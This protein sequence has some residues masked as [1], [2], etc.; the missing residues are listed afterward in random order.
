MPIVPGTTA[1]V[2][3]VAAARK[4]IAAEI[5][6]PVAVKAAGGG[7]GKG[8]RV[9]ATA[10]QLAEAFRAPRARRSGSSATRRVYLERYLRPPRHVEVQVLA[11]DH[12]NIVHLGERD[13]SLQ[14]RH[15][16]LIEETPAAGRD[17]AARERIGDAAVAGARRR[18]Y[19]A[20]APRVPARRDGEYYFIEMNTRMQ[21]EHRSPR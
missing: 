12:G 5:G 15:Q 10:G 19:A 20:R 8:F 2:K 13:C 16:K 7:G 9:A 21:V 17:A 11:D 14:R 3:T 18:L 1:P 4:I 6:F